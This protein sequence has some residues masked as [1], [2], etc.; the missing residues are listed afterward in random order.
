MEREWGWGVCRHRSGR[1][2][3]A[4]ERSEDAI[5]SAAEATRG[6]GAGSGET[7][8]FVKFKVTGK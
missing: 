1:T 2:L 4:T 5:L 8:S 6:V 3:G 7:E